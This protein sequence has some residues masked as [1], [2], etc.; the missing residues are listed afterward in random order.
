MEDGMYKDIKVPGK[1]TTRTITKKR[2]K[3]KNPWK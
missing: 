2:K 3:A 1:Q